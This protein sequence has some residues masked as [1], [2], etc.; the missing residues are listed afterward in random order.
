MEFFRA[1]SPEEVPD[2]QRAQ[3]GRVRDASVR[4]V[5]RTRLQFGDLEQALSNIDVIQHDSLD[6]VLVTHG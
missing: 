5:P 3:T 6:F 4:V 1:F 2:H